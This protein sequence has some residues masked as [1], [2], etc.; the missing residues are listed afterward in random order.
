MFLMMAIMNFGVIL[1]ELRDS[2]MK[3]C[4]KLRKYESIWDKYICQLKNYTDVEV[5]CS[6]NIESQMDDVVAVITTKLSEDDIQNM[7]K[8]KRVFLFKTG[9]DGLPEKVLKNN[10]ITVYPSYANADI[11]AEHA[12]A[13][14]FSLLHRVV[15]FDRDLRN[16]IWFSSGYNYNWTSLRHVK[17]GIL[18]Y[19]HI[20]QNVY[21]DIKS[22]CNQI[23]VLNK[24]GQYPDNIDYAD[25]LDELLKWSDLLFIC[26]PKNVETVGLIG[27]NE[28]ELLKNKYIV[29]ISRAEICDEEALYS[30]LKNKQICG[31]ASDVWYCLPNKNDRTKKAVAANYPFKDL[32]NVVMSPHCATHEYSSHERYIADAVKQCIDYLKEVKTDDSI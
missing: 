13:L 17:V 11:I 26:I 24:S 30:A 7:P 5:V 1:N 22:F 12:V 27:K 15:E 23:K 9:Q 4:I 10:G 18:G 6:G 25:N 14:A 31:Y 29:N 3:V 32:D 8:L 2:L 28:L 19:G 20:G 21:K 16:D